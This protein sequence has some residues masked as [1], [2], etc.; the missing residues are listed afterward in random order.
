MTMLRAI[1]KVKR[2]RAPRGCLYNRSRDFRNFFRS[3]P[4]QH[5]GSGAAEDLGLLL[6][7]QDFGL[8]H[9]KQRFRVAVLARVVAQRGRVLV[10]ANADP[11]I[12]NDQNARR[13]SERSPPMRNR[14]CS[15]TA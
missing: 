3:R 14:S 8:A 6:F 10:P 12:T 11:P 4:I 7:R 5:L 9:E 15:C 2:T 1:M 13:S